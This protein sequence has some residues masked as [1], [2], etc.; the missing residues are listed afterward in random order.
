MIVCISLWTYN[1]ETSWGKACVF[2]L[3]LCLCVGGG[4]WMAGRAGLPFYF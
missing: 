2:V 4:G 1:L 3:N